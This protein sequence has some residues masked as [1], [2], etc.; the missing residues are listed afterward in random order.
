MRTHNLAHKWTKGQGFAESY[1]QVST[2]CFFRGSENADS[3]D[4]YPQG[5][6][7]CKG[8]IIQMIIAE[9]KAENLRTL[10]T[11]LY[12]VKYAFLGSSSKVKSPK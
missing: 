4:I 6:Q 2:M 11:Y 9:N 10:S 3:L 1:K 12:T 7:S 5:I 8:D